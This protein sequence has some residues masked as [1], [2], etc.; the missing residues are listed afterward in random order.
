MSEGRTGRK[1]D[2]WVQRGAVEGGGR[3][4]GVESRLKGGETVVL[5]HV[6]KRLHT[7]EKRKE[8]GRTGFSI[9][10]VMTPSRNDERRDG[11]TVFPAL[12]RP[13]KRILAF[14]FISPRHAREEPLSVQVGS[15]A[16]KAQTMDRGRTD[17]GW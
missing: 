3:L 1:R 2:A 16:R 5:Q 8:G 13:K 12:S 10:D 6:Q 17:L 14:L 11:L 4:T 9:P 15:S 7:E